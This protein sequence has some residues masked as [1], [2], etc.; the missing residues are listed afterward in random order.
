MIYIWI[1]D[2]AKEWK[3]LK[4]VKGGGIVWAKINLEDE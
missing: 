2:K 4:A 1:L 3:K